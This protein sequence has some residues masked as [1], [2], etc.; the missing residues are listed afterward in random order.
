MAGVVGIEPT[1]H[2]IKT[3]G[4][5]TKR[6]RSKKKEVR[7]DINLF[8]QF[9]QFSHSGVG[10]NSLFSTQVRYSRYLCFTVSIQF[11][12]L[13]PQYNSHQYTDKHLK[14]YKL[15]QSLRDKEWSYR[16]IS[17]YLNEKGVLTANN[18]KWGVSGNS[19]YSV[20]KRFGARQERLKSRS[21]KYPLVRG[22][23]LMEFTR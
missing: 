18:K 19:V 21:K 16:R 23:M 11:N 22:K 1:V 15:I 6:T 14:L 8:H 17:K 3:R 12:N 4:Y 13:N 7:N 10:E 9:N 2:A 20:L 5:C